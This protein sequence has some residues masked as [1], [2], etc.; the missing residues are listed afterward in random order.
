MTFNANAT[1]AA[2]LA[3]LQNITFNSIVLTPIV[4]DRPIT[5][6]LKSGTLGYQ[7]SMSQTVE[8]MGPPPLAVGNPATNYKSE[9]TDR[10]IAHGL[11]GAGRVR[12]LA[13]DRGRH[14]AVH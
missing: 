7:S 11:A 10:R 6:A 4:A 8:L 1:Q 14:F 5:Y 9:R 12:Q 2:V 13:A 3:V